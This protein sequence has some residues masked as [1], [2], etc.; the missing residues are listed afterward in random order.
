MVVM[1]GHVGQSKLLTMEFWSTC[2]KSKEYHEEKNAH[3]LRTR[4]L[5]AI[6]F[7]SAL[8]ASNTT[9]ECEHLGKTCAFERR[10]LLRSESPLADRVF[11][12]IRAQIATMGARQEN[13]FIQMTSIYFGKLPF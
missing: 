8:Q 4:K 2:E 7:G 9:I 5:L 13:F 11:E 3:E 1:Q 12:Q 6:E 10:L